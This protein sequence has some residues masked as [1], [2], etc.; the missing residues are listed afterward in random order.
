MKIRTTPCIK[1]T[2]KVAIKATGGGLDL[3]DLVYTKPANASTVEDLLIPSSIRPSAP[4]MQPCLST[5]TQSLRPGTNSVD[6]L[7]AS[8]IT[9]LHKVRAVQTELKTPVASPATE[10]MS[11]VEP[12]HEMPIRYHHPDPITSSV[13]IT[14]S[15]QIVAFPT[16]NPIN[17]MQEIHP[18]GPESVKALE[19]AIELQLKKSQDYQNPNSSVQQIDY[20]S[21]GLLTIMDII[22]AKRLRVL[23]VMDASANDPSYTPNHESIEDSLIDMINYASFGISFL[24]GKIEGQDSTKNI[25]NK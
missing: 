24:R 2:S 12:E 3:T 10:P 22:N 25:F 13:P 17:N 14:S 11:M 20:Y 1:L 21:N 9:K 18:K 8:P 5:T 23:S 16:T 15:D 4:K 6:T 7:K 19:E